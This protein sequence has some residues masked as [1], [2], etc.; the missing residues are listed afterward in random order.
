M[1]W[2]LIVIYDMIV[3]VVRTTI[4]RLYVELN[5]LEKLNQQQKNEQYQL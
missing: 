4:F 5:G 3:F 2:T 1:S